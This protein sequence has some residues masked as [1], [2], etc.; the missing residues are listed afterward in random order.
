MAK[1]NAI[2]C[3][4]ASITD[5]VDSKGKPQQIISTMIMSE[6]TKCFRFEAKTLAQ[7]E[8]AMQQFADELASF[9]PETPYSGSPSLRKGERKPNGYDANRY[10]FTRYVNLAKATKE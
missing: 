8:T 10:R 7:I 1:F 9:D 4:I 6:A 3:P 2:F 5:I